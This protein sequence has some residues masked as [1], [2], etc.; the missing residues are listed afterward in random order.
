MPTCAI[1]GCNNGSGREKPREDGRIR[2]LFL[3]K[4]TEAKKEWVE[5]INR[6]NFKPTENTRIC[7]DH[8]TEDAYIPGSVTLVV[9][10]KGTEFLVQISTQKRRTLKMPKI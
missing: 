6:E 2:L 10:L 3:Y 8:F 9:E 5:R 1:W 4:H 7:D